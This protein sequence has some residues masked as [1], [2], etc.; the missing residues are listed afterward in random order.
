[1]QA[2]RT[3]VSEEISSM[4]VLFMYLNF[5]NFPVYFENE[6]RTHAF[7]YEYGVH[8][9]LGYGSYKYVHFSIQY[10]FNKHHSQAMQLVTFTI[11]LPTGDFNVWFNDGVMLRKSRE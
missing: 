1:M 10:V 5:F 7:M 8:N 3:M 2:N 11:H 4:S 9:H 6:M